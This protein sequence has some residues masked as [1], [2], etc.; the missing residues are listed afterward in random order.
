MRKLKIFKY[1]TVVA[2]RSTKLQKAGPVIRA[3][4][5]FELIYG[6]FVLLLVFSRHTDKW[7]D[8]IPLSIIMF[9]ITELRHKGL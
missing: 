9:R 8:F 5:L 4:V 7:V 2:N 6:R 3:I 1:V